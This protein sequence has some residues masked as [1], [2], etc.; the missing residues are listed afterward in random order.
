MNSFFYYTR[1]TQAQYIRNNS[2]RFSAMRLETNWWENNIAVV[3]THLVALKDGML[4]LPGPV[5][6]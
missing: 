4:R 1:E 5:E 3:N 2:I 6:I